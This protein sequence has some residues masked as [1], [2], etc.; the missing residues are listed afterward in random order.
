MGGDGECTKGQE[1]EQKC[2]AMG[3]GEL[4]VTTRKSQMLGEQ[5]PPRTPQGLHQLKYP[6]KGRNNLWNH[7]QRLGM[8]PG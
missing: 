6:T 3:D 8:A 2:V 4:G 7:I 1:I 5:E